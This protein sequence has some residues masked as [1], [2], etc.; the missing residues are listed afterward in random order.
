VTEQHQAGP[1]APPPH[2][3]PRE[4][5][6]DADGYIVAS[7][8]ATLAPPA[9]PPAPPGLAEPMGPTGPEAPVPRQAIRVDEAGYIRQPAAPPPPPR[10]VPTAAEVWT[11]VQ[12]Y[13][14]FGQYM[15]GQN[16]QNALRARDEETAR[17]RAE[18]QRW[19]AAV[20]C[21]LEQVEEI[22]AGRA[23]G[24]PADAGAVK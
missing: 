20:G 14:Q 3:A 24:N 2:P 8:L 10:G 23:G 15:A 16:V 21:S 5:L 7:Q 13:R 9:R 18:L 11:L 19:Q 12:N 1:H 6:T 4:I 17:L 22:E